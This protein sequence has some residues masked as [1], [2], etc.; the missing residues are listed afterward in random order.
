MSS[1]LNQP[2]S[3]EFICDTSDYTCKYRNGTPCT[4][5]SQCLLTSM[6]SGVCVNKSTDN[7]LN[8][9]CPCDDTTTCNESYEINICK[10]IPGQPCESNDDCDS[11]NCVNSVC[12]NLV[13]LGYACQDNC[14]NGTC[15]NGFCQPD[16]IVTGEV[17]SVCINTLCTQD[18]RQGARCNN[19]L[20][21]VC[22]GSVGSCKSIVYMNDVCDLDSPCTSE[23]NCVTFDNVNYSCRYNIQDTTLINPDNT[24]PLVSTRKRLVDQYRCLSNSGYLCNIGSDC[25]S[26]LC[27]STPTILRYTFNT[28]SQI[29]NQDDITNMDL[30]KINGPGINRQ[31]GDIYFENYRIQANCKAQLFLDV[32]QLNRQSHY[33]LITNPNLNSFLYYIRGVDIDKA[34]N[35]TPKI[36]NQV[37]YDRFQYANYLSEANISKPSQLS[38]DTFVEITD[39]TLFGQDGIT[40]PS[41]YTN[42]IFTNDLNQPDAYT[43]LVLLRD[44]N[45]RYV[46]T[47]MFYTDITRITFLQFLSETD[48]YY[49]K[50]LQNNTLTNIS[51]IKGMNT[52]ENHLLVY[53]N[54]SIY[55]TLIGRRPTTNNNINF[56]N[57]MSFTMIVSNSGVSNLP[58]TSF[59]GVKAKLISSFINRD[60]EIAYTFNLNTIIILS[61]N[62]NQ[63]TIN[64]LFIPSIYTLI[65]FDADDKSVY[66]K[67]RLDNNFTN[68]IIDRENYLIT[69]PGPM[70]IENTIT[71]SE[72]GYLVVGNRSCV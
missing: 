46:I 38:N 22:S 72:F 63:I 41:R 32:R 26:N 69:L 42:S 13:P 11:Y 23:F 16:N 53:S 48:Y 5:G 31:S 2:C 3:S 66:C 64:R 44:S 14:L 36:S 33:L 1:C 40:W 67:V 12:S 37:L 19:N 70:S 62:N 55:I 43:L 39:V 50:Y 60:Y 49:L 51:N 8:S 56:V 30:E 28:S 47:F 52:K 10:L 29:T 6:C 54:D 9:H 17:D 61:N 59:N 68:I 57:E 21:C 15:N 34:I 58:N 65:D 7:G 24:C 71:N 27:S 35:N 4:L 18:D 25:N 20:T 45:D